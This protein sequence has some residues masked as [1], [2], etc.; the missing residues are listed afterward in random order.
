GR[1]ARG[2]AGA[3]RGASSRRRSDADHDLP[4]RDPGRGGLGG[5]GSGPAGV[6]AGRRR[7]RLILRTE[8]TPGIL[9]ESPSGVRRDPAPCARAIGRTTRRTMMARKIRNS[10]NDAAVYER[11]AGATEQIVI[12]ETG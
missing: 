10:R 11:E 9:R 3:C 5:V 1:H 2:G 4:A 6:G 7:N 8:S 12:A